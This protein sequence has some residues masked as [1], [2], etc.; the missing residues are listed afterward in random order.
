MLNKRAQILFDKELWNIL[1][2]LANEKNLSIGELVRKAVK[3]QYLDEAK[4]EKRSKAI[5]RT[6]DRR[7][8]FKGKINYKEL[9]DYGRKY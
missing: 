9:I 1:E 4:F 5:Q 7:L 8:I 3:K 6:L 2:K